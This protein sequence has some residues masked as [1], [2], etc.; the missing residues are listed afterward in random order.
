MPSRIP[1]RG[2]LSLTPCLV[3]LQGCAPVL[4]SNGPSVAAMSQPPVA[5]VARSRSGFHFGLGLGAGAA[6][7]TCDG[8]LFDSEAGFSGFVSLARSVGKKTLLGIE[9]TGWTME[10][11]GTPNRVLSLMAHLT[12]YLNRSSGLFLRTGLGVI[13]YREDNEGRPDVSATGLGFSGRL[14]YELGRGRVAVV[15]YV[16]YLRSLG[17]AGVKV[18]GD[19]VDPDVT[20]SN[21]QLGLSVALH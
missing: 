19:D 5:E 17:G 10:T 14:G 8:C 11:L 20:I 3:L 9:A 16:G 18:D 2:L 7:V 21:F 1:F 13:A 15:P 4:G 6:D 12:E